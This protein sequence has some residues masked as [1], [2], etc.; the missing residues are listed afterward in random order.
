[1]EKTAVGSDRAGRLLCTAGRP[2]TAAGMGA[3][4]N[5]RAPAPGCRCRR[6]GRRNHR[7][8]LL[9]LQVYYTQKRRKTQTNFGDIMGRVFFISGQTPHSKTWTNPRDCAIN[10][11]YRCALEPGMAPWGFFWG[12]RPGCGLA[13]LPKAPQKTKS[14]ALAAVFESSALKRRKSHDSF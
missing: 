2:G 8:Q 12:C 11:L 6:R 10:K 3:A 14:T 9:I 4:G 7:S 13:A 5:S 1:M